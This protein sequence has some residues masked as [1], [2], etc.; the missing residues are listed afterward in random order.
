M[1]QKFPA[2]DALKKYNKK[3]KLKTIPEDSV[4]KTPRM[5]RKLSSSEKAE[6]KIPK[7]K[8]VVVSGR[9]RR[10]SS[11]YKPPATMEFEF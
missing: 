7:E 5:A 2:Y 10:V 6:M 3:R 11:E 9:R 1:T 4:L 8:N